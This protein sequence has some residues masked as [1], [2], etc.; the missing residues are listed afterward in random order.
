MRHG[1]AHHNVT[2]NNI[3]HGSYDAKDPAFD[4]GMRHNLL[5]PSLTIISRSQMQRRCRV[6]T[7]GMHQYNTPKCSCVLL[8]YVYGI[9]FKIITY[10]QSS[11][12]DEM[13]V[14]HTK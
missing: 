6:I 4:P 12:D 10:K 14:I 13:F 5:N 7:T 1:N 11:N 9:K 8:L 3:K 2:K